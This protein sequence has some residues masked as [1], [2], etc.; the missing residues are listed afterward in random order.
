MTKTE[1]TVFYFNRH[2]HLSHFS[3]FL[4]RGATFKFIHCLFN[5][6]NV[7]LLNF[8][9]KVR[10]F[11]LTAETPSPKRFI[12]DSS[13]SDTDTLGARIWWTDVSFFCW[14]FCKVSLHKILRKWDIESE[15]QSQN[16]G[17]WRG[18][19]RLCSYMV[20]IPLLE[21]ALFAGL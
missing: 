11:E 1:W 18:C 12:S 10:N 13:K 6:I 7:Y 8:F 15:I 21:A 5:N 20:N 14:V 3:I 2:T 17:A 9:I 4:L 19:S 16:I